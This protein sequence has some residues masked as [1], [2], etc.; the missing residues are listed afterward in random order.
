MLMDISSELVHSL[1]PVFMATVL[2][3]SMLTIGILEGVA[4]ATAAITKVFSGALSD[5]LGK[6]KFPLVLGYALAA[7]TKP[8]FPLATP[9][10][11]VFV[12]RFVDRLGKVRL[13]RGAAIRHHHRQSAQAKVLR[14][15]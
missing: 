2:G 1:L 4:E 8:V 9:I 5:Y 13:R 12:A 14:L 6:R 10:G 3:S 11:G 7:L 15:Q